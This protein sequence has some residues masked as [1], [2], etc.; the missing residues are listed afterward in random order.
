MPDPCSF[1]LLDFKAF[2]AP[3]SLRLHSSLSALVW[4]ELRARCRRHQGFEFV[5]CGYPE[6]TL[7]FLTAQSTY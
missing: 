5:F 4:I 3:D 7:T 6:A 2:G 1:G